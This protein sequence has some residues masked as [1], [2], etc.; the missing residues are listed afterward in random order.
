MYLLDRTSCSFPRAIRPFNK[1]NLLRSQAFCVPWAFAPFSSTGEPTMATATE[2]TAPTTIRKTA[3]K[4]NT[5]ITHALPHLDEILAYWML[6]KF[7]GEECLKRGVKIVFWTEH[8]PEADAKLADLHEDGSVL[9]CGIGGGKLDEHPTTTQPGKT[10]ECAATLAAKMFGVAEKPELKKLLDYI[11][12]NDIRAQGSPFDLAA[13]LRA[14]YRQHRDNPMVAIKWVLA[15]FDAHYAE[16]EEFS[17]ALQ[18]F[19]IN[20]EREEISIGGNKRITIATIRTDNES[21]NRCSRFL[22]IDLLIQV[23]TTGNV[24]ICTSKKGGVPSLDDVIR[25]LRLHEQTAKGK[26]VTDSWT[27]LAKEGKMPGAEEWYYFVQGQMILNGSLTTQNTP[28]KLSVEDIQAAV[29]IGLNP[30]LFETSRFRE[31]QK[32]NCDRRCSWFGYGLSRCQT[33]RR[34]RK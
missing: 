30:E 14:M 18:E 26:V 31:C 12:A 13:S 4:I 1:R 28:T 6:L 32:G 15:A 11:A 24:Q 33:I 23:N 10:G 22:G 7:Q 16:Q 2:T 8:G 29:K 3:R 20:A 5:F 21:A 25:I 19:R 34:P 17:A 27:A 9:I